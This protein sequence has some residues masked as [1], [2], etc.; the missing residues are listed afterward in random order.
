MIRSG[1]FQARKSKILKPI[2]LSQNIIVQI[3]FYLQ[4]KVF[5]VKNFVLTF[6]PNQIISLIK[7]IRCAMRIFI[8]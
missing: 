6:K 4:Y 7:N 3:V 2:P 5:D 8:K 1:F